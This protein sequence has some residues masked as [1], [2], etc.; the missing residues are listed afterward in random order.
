MGLRHQLLAA[1]PSLAALIGASAQAQSAAN[2]LAEQV[3]AAEKREQGLQDAPVAIPAFTSERRDV[4]I[5]SIR[6]ITN[7]TPGLQ[8]DGS[9]LAARPRPADPR[10]LGGRVRGGRRRSSGDCRGASLTGWRRSNFHKRAHQ[11]AALLGGLII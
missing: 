8:L 1:S 11:S 2:T 6:D 3:V 4:D 7:F 10:A 5:Q 9:R